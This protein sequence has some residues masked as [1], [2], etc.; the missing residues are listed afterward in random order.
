MLEYLGTFLGKKV[1]THW[2]GSLQKYINPWITWMMD[3][4]DRMKPAL[5]KIFETLIN[6]DLVISHLA[7]TQWPCR[8]NNSFELEGQHQ[9]EMIYKSNLSHV[10]QP[11][12]WSW[13][14]LLRISPFVLI[15][16]N[17]TYACLG[18]SS[19]ISLEMRIRNAVIP[20]NGPPADVQS[21]SLWFAARQMF[22][23]STI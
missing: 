22:R 21:V 9:N 7:V 16:F 18:I 3:R 10:K 15:D 20:L 2:F 12:M 6:V 4:I 11:K 19:F 23:L 14:L 5:R 13:F 17:M 8:L 1:I